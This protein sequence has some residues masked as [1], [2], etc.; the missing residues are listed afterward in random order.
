M[1]IAVFGGTFDPPHNG[2]LG[3]CLFA[4]ELL[5]LDRLI[6]SV[7][8]NPFKEFLGASDN[9]RRKMAELLAAEINKTGESA[10]AS[11]WEL[12]RSGHSYTIDLLRY[13]RAIYPA[14]EMVLL[15]GEDSYRE[16]PRWKS[17]EEVIRFCP[18]AV[19]RREPQPGED[20]NIFAGA[21]GGIR[22]IDYDMQV[23]A[24][25][26]R[27]RIA[28]R[29]SITQLLPSSIRRYIADHELYQR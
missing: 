6:I 13:V 18:I 15:V 1:R 24:T 5:G 3:I 12:S 17:F 26:I 29:E 14:A 10:E 20:N 4:R 11:G 22:C 27:T 7:S 2:H 16:M 21:E 25:M 8:N 23:S 19:F 28:A 9:D